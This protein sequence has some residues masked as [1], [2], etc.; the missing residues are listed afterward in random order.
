MGPKAHAIS[1]CQPTVPVLA[2]VSLMAAAGEKIPRTLTMMGGP[3]DTRRSPTAGNNFAKQRPLS[4]VEAKGIQ[5]VPVRYS[6][7]IRRVYPGFLQFA[8]FVPMNPDPHM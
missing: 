5:R 4:W 8:G 1:V 6:R 7:F 2:A 3:I